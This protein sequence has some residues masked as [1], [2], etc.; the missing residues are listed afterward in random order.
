MKTGEIP[1]TFT[2]INNKINKITKGPSNTR[3]NQQNKASK[4][5][6]RYNPTETEAKDQYSDIH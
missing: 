2:E 3:N 1:S 5:K 6:N 4:K